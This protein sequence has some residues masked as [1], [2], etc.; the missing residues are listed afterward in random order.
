VFKGE[1]TEIN[2]GTGKDV[3]TESIADAGDPLQI[4]IYPDSYVD[5]PVSR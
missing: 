1:S 4:K 5:I 2:Y 3:S